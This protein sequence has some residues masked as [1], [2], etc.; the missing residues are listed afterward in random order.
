MEADRSVATGAGHT[1]ECRGCVNRRPSASQTDPTP[2]GAADHSHRRLEPYR[3]APGDP[4]RACSVC[5]KAERWQLGAAIVAGA[6]NRGM[7]TQYGLTEAAVRKHRASHLPL[8]LLKAA[9]PRLRRVMRCSNG[10]A[11][12]RPRAYDAQA[13]AALDV[14]RIGGPARA[15]REPGDRPGHLH[16]ITSRPEPR[17]RRSCRSCSRRSRSHRRNP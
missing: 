6:P 2:L 16:R 8:A 11:M 14:R 9:K 15:A 5:S 17:G 7:A 3:A 13:A 12:E 4:M 1:Q 10:K